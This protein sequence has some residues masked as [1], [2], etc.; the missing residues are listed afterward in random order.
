MKKRVAIWIYGG[1]GTGIFSQGYAA[2]EKLLMGLSVA[3]E[4]RVYSQFPV[5]KDFVSTNFVVRAA[6][7]NVK[8]GFVRWLILIFY[9]LRD[10]RQNRFHLLFS[11]WGFP[12]GFIGTLLSKIVRI[13]S[14][15]Y[16]LGGDAAGIPVINFGILHRPILRRFAFW[17]YL[18][19]DLLF[20]ISEYQRAILMAHG[21]TRTIVIPWGVELRRYRVAVPGSNTTLR[22]IHVGHF[23]KVK[24]QI[25]L[26][27]AF[28]LIQ[29][30][31]A[32]ELRIYGEDFLNGE[33]QKKCIELSIESK[34]YFMGMVPYDK[35]PDE[36]S[37]A[38]IMLHTSWSEGQSMALTE[39]AA[40]GVL[41]AGTRVGLLFDLGDEGGVAVDVG[42]FERLAAR[43]LSILENKDEWSQKVRFARAWAETHDLM[44]TTQ[45]IVEH[46]DRTLAR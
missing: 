21:I 38:D 17:A 3:Y 36:Y 8:W 33:L 23:N 43:V 35:M 28:A 1:I 27:K 37:R 4:I 26:L 6:P 42:D 32:A 31:H 20:G 11:F 2:L 15:V 24:D 45:R 40:S 5:N 29:K 34:V 41:L 9:F 39:A 12:A 30:K 14:A 44:W 7:A 10:H 18:K 13:P 25:T 46:L 19:T 16:V 22:F